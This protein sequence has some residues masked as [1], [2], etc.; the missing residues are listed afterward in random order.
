MLDRDGADSQRL[1]SHA[2]R[3]SEIRVDALDVLRD[4]RKDAVSGTVCWTRQTR[5]LMM[6]PGPGEAQRCERKSQVV[7]RGRSP[8]C[9]GSGIAKPLVLG[10]TKAWTNPAIASRVSSPAAR[11]ATVAA[12]AALVPNSL[13]P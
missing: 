6:S 11:Y 12:W 4:H 10:V 3:S 5:G 13:K 8:D 2:G 7:T 1:S 9:A